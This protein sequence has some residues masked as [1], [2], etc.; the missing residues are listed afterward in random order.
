MQGSTPNA[1]RIVFVCWGSTCR[2]PLAAVLLK[3]LLADYPQFQASARGFDAQEGTEA[4][5]HAV[6]AL[7]EWDSLLAQE[8]SQHRSAQ[9]TLED[10]AHAHLI[11]A[12]DL[13]VLFKLRP[14]SAAEKEAIA[15]ST[16]IEAPTSVIQTYD[17][18][19]EKLILITEPHAGVHSVHPG[20]SDPYGG[21]CQDYCT[22][23]DIISTTL[24]Q[25]L[26]PFLSKRFGVK[27]SNVRELGRIASRGA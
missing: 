13:N 7:E 12:M 1:I 14:F 8:L 2:S 22:C 27:I 10:M 15:Q 9:L 24:T 20:I 11:V 16:F 6:T 23:R 19:A 5:A 3:T 4:S 17:G 21:P 25:T 18:L 26:L